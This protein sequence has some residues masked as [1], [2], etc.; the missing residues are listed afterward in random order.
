M[1]ITM[2]MAILIEA[3]HRNGHEEDED[4]VPR[5]TLLHLN[6]DGRCSQPWLQSTP[7]PRPTN[8]WPEFIVVPPRI[9][10]GKL[11]EKSG[12]LTFDRASIFRFVTRVVN[13]CQK[14][15][16]LRWPRGHL[17]CPLIFNQAGFTQ[18][19]SVT[20]GLLTRHVHR[21]RPSEM[22]ISVSHKLFASTSK[23]NEP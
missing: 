7:A 22:Q 13:K 3:T 17:L 14:F 16:S 15:S 10:I 12:N 5:E 6:D 20:E 23:I 21:W 9:R 11:P 4:D 18:K 1:R 19:Y 8:P 2:T